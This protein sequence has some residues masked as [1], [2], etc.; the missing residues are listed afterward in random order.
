MRRY[1]KL[2]VFLWV[3]PSLCYSAPNASERFWKVAGKAQVYATSDFDDGT[4]QGWSGTG[5]A[6]S[7]AQA[8]SGTYSVTIG[9]TRTLTK[10]VTHSTNNLVFW[11]YRTVNCANGLTVTVG[12]TTCTYSVPADSAW[13]QYT[14]Y[15]ADS[16]ATINFTQS[17]CGGTLYVDSIKVPT[18]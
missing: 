17:T 1:S 18:P 8:Q 7:T 12:A 14:C 16:S 15:L 6:V 9:S 3:L 5:T 10:D 11:A 13:H 2:L 4:L